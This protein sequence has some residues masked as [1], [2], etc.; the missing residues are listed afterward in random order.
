[1]LITFNAIGD[2]PYISMINNYQYLQITVC[3]FFQIKNIFLVTINYYT[4][5]YG[6]IKY[7]TTRS[8]IFN[9]VLWKKHAICRQH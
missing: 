9:I 1:M 6:E 7:V 3:N 5:Y 2:I 4:Y 8:V